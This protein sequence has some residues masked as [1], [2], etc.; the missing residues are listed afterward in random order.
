M[1]VS[2]VNAQVVIKKAVSNHLESGTEMPVLTFE[3][4]T[5][6][7]VKKT[8]NAEDFEGRILVLEFWATWCAPCIKQFPK[9]NSLTKLFSEEELVIISIT[10]E[11][12]S[13]IEPFLKRRTLDTWIASDT[14][15]SVIEAYGIDAFPTTVVI[16]QQGKIH[17]YIK[18]DELTP[19]YIEDLLANKAKLKTQ[20]IKV[21]NSETINVQ[22]NA[23]IKT[24]KVNEAEE[25]VKIKSNA[26]VTEKKV[27]DE[28][29]NNES[30]YSVTIVE[31]TEDGM[32]GGLMGKQL[33]IIDQKG[34][35]V[36]KA[37]AEVYGMSESLITGP[38]KILSKKISVK[39]KLPRNQPE[40]VDLL[41]KKALLEK[42]KFKT[43]MVEKDI[44]LYALSAPN[45]LTKYLKEASEG[46]RSGFSA[47]HGVMAGR[48]YS[49]KLLIKNLESELGRT[50]YDATNLNE[51]YDYDLYWDHGNPESLVNALEEQLGLILEEKTM[52][53]ESL[54]VEPLSH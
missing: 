40:V 14:D 19:E 15:K 34:W 17:D 22:G 46:N 1:T 39:V 42:L 23:K 3:S 48:R 50:I 16:N 18:A 53:M 54:V 43:K 7:A 13:A 35:T 12:Q 41:L 26:V 10:D 32:V 44:T 36:K 21:S 24:F 52:N 29:P 45:G 47:D 6:G 11:P 31:E 51:K 25:G 37:L 5:K 20:T 33:G 38:D 30:I 28:A 2:L 4:M 27:E 49:L 8:F 9:L